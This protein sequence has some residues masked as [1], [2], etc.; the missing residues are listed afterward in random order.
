MEVER[1]ETNRFY[2]RIIEYFVV[3]F[4]HHFVNSTTAKRP[5]FAVPMGP[6]AEICTCAL[7]CG[8]CIQI[9]QG[10][11]SIMMVE[12]NLHGKLILLVDEPHDYTYSYHS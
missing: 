4:H 3:I 1:K 5:D 10:F 11:P 8:A 7:T 2:K 12:S 6:A 9:A